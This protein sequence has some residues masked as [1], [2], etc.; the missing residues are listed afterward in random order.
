[1]DEM[2]RQKTM[3]TP[4]VTSIVY[5]GDELPRYLLSNLRYLKK[6]FPTE[7]FVFIS[8]NECSLKRVSELGVKVWKFENL[9]TYQEKYQKYLIHDPE[10]RSNF[11]F[12]TLARFFA[13]HEYMSFADDSPHLH[14][15]ADNFLFPNFPFN[16]FRKLE[17]PIAF[18]LESSSMGVASLLYLRNPNSAEQLVEFSVREI[19]SNP[20][21]TD[22]TIL[23]KIAIS[24]DINS[25][26]LRTIP[27]PLKNALRTLQNSDLFTVENNSGGVFDAITHGQFLLGIDAR[28]FRGK[29]K[30]YTS[31]INHEL[32][33]RLL[34][35]G[36]SRDG[37]LY[38]LDEKQKWPIYN[39]HNH[40]KDLRI[41]SSRSRN[42]LLYKRVSHNN[43]KP[44]AEID[45]IAFFVV[46][47]ASL[48][49][50]LG[51]FLLFA[52]PRESD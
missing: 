36:L 44:K 21:G 1:M 22:M 31:E 17:S 29:R 6:T 34:E 28:N 24:Q 32:N 11:W 8:D 49:R 43:G 39:L 47:L 38:L 52:R 5:L 50:R 16:F 14:L 13:I 45:L 30:I 9:N 15:E 7:K 27:R 48:V 41:Y 25:F 3:T 2:R 42:K 33:A 18:P 12:H 35:Y 51:K 37:Y 4:L 26:K 10:F 40:A 23:G 46:V 19:L 20:K